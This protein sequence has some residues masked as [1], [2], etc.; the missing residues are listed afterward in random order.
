MEERD[1]FTVELNSE[2]IG[3]VANGQRRAVD[4]TKRDLL[5]CQE[6][7]ISTA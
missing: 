6:W 5:S 2:Y 1:Q 3:V 7:E 4:I